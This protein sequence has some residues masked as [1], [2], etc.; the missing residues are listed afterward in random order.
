MQRIYQRVLL[1]GL[2]GALFSGC[3]MDTANSSSPAKNQNK[4]QNKSQN[5]SK[6]TNPKTAG[7]TLLDF[8]YPIEIAQ[9]PLTH[10]TVGVLFPH[11]QVTDN[12]KPYINRFENA[13]AN[14]IKEIFQKRGYQVETL[15]NR[16]ALTP[17]LKHKMWSVADVGGWIGILEDVKMDVDNPEKTDTDTM[18][19]QSSGAVWLKFFE[20]ETGRVIHNFGIQI[21]GAQAISHIYTYRTT[22][23]GGFARPSAISEYVRDKSNDDAIRRILNRVYRIVMKRLVDELTDKNINRYRNTI[24]QIKK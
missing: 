3:A 2:A 4:S 16:D 19:D 21:G 6:A 1:A 20:P 17:E 23:S 14:Q 8:S 18:V 7:S 9:E 12:L 5:Q 22:N 11:I 15:S 24:E 13:L 10:H